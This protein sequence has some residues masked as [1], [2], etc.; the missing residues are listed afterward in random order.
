[1]DELMTW[2][3]NY[4]FDQQIG[5]IFTHNLAPDTPSQSDGTNRLVVLNM[6]WF[7]HYEL[8]FALAHEIGHILNGD[9]GINKY[10][11]ETV[12]TKKEYQANLTGIRL[13]LKYC[14]LHDI[15]IDNPV[16]FCENFGVPEKL[17]YVVKL[18]LGE[19]R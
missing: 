9:Q 16:N 4:G 1:M 6:E 7:P 3:S 14:D 17:D 12:G 8:P 13:L 15:N 19:K 11:A 5:F 18:I 2:L 10:C